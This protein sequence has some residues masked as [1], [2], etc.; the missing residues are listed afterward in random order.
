[1]GSRGKLSNEKVK[2][3]KKPYRKIREIVEEYILS[4]L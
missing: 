2:E 4:P 3:G 1:V